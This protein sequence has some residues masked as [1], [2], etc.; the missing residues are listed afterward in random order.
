MDV[1]SNRPLV[2]QIVRLVEENIVF[3]ET[4]AAE[5]SNLTFMRS[6]FEEHIRLKPIEITGAYYMELGIRVVGTKLIQEW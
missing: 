6:E 3:G 2:H 1:D 5:D 4:W